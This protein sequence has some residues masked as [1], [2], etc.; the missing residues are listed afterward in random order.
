MNRNKMNLDKTKHLHVSP[1]VHKK[2]KAFCATKSIKLGVTSDKAILLFMQN[3]PE[4]I[5]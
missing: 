2:F 5:R 3:P 4:D 1:S